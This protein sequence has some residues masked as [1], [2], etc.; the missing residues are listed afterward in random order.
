M[1]IFCDSQNNFLQSFLLVPS[2]KAGA[3]AT[4]VGSGGNLLNQWLR[5]LVSLSSTEDG[6][7][8][9]LKVTGILE[10][11]A[12]LAPHR[13]HALLTLH[14]LCF[15]PANKSHIMAN[16]MTLKMGLN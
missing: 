14:N 11:L 15:S 3:K 5:L 12:E 8:S 4:S 9:I 2:H 16:G 7:Q 10:L 13:Q 1:I 6:Q